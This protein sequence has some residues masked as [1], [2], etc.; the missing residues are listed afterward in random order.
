MKYQSYPNTKT[1]PNRKRRKSERNS[2]FL[3]NRK[4]RRTLQ[5]AARTARREFMGG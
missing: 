3:A 4:A 5:K 2:V 1:V